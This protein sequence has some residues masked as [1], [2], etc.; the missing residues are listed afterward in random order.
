MTNRES[1]PASCDFDALARG[2]QF[3]DRIGVRVKASP[4]AIFDALHTV[5]L[6]DIKLAWLL[7][8]IRY[9]PSRLAGCA[10]EF[11]PKAPFISNLTEG[12][13]LVLHDDEPHEIIT[14][15]AGRLH[16]IRDQSPLRFDNREAFDAFEDPESEKLFMSIRVIPSD[17]PGEHWL[18]LDHATR[19]LSP[20]AERK[21]RRYWRIIKPTGAFV[22]REL[23][24]AVRAKAQADNASRSLDNTTTRVD[25][26]K[27]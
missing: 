1:V 9:L 11:D 24:R 27:R 4:E 25:L 22:S 17:V 16:R 19:A 15:W 12:A 5:G 10:P 20:E 23:L 26:R 8:E 13:T 2:A 18:V 6:Q 21:F 7:G 14:G 3:R